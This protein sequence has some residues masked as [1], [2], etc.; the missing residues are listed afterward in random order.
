M[1]LNR[2]QN[3]LQT[4]FTDDRR[5]PHN[6]RRL[7]FWYDA[8]G[9][10]QE[11]FD[12]LN[13]EGIE[14]IQLAD[15]PFYTKYRLLIEDPEQ[16][17]LLYAPFAEPAPID[18]WLLDLQL[19]GL[20]FAADQ[21]ALLY[22]DLGFHD[23]HLETVIRQ[24]PNFFNSNKRTAAIV[25][26]QLAP[27]TT[28]KTL[29]L[30]LL[31]AIAGLKVP[32]TSALIRHIFM[33]G[34]LESDNELWQEITRLLSAETFWQIAQD[35]FHFQDDKPSLKKLLTRLLI[36]HL[37]LSLQGQLPESL[38]TYRLQSGQQAYAFIDQWLRDQRDLDAFKDFSRQIGDDLQIFQ[39]L[40][41]LSTETLQEAA[42][43]EAIDQVIIRQCVGDILAQSK[44]ISHWR[45]WLPSRRPLPWFDKYQAIYDALLAA[46]ALLE[47]YSQYKAGFPITASQLFSAYSQELYRFDQAYR[48]FIVAS[49]AA[50]GDVLKPV[51]EQIE[52]LYVNWYLA[53]LGEVWS[54]SLGQTWSIEGFFCQSKFFTTY[55]A[56]ILKRSDRE[57]VFVIIS[58]ALRY[59][60][61]AELKDQIEKELRGEI[62]LTSQLS[63]LPS[64][65]RLGMAALLP[66]TSL[67]LIP[68]SNEVKR[69]GLSTLGAEARQK[70]LEQ[71]SQVCSKVLSSAEILDSNTEQGRELIKPHRLFYIY[72]DVID[73]IGDK[74][75]SEREVFT[76][77][78]KANQQ[79][80]RL[81][82]RLCNSLNGTHVI[83]TA[84]HGFLYQRRS[85]EEPDKL[86][87]PKADDIIKTNRR[88][89]LRSQAIAEKGTVA[90]PVPSVDREITAVVPRGSMRFSVQGAG[91]QYVHGGASLQEVCV[92]VI[93]YRHKRAEKGDDGPI[94]KVGVQ[95][96][97]RTR[98][99]TN[100]RFRVSLIQSDAA[101]GRWRSRT[102]TLGLYD[103][104]NGQALTDIKTIDLSSS[105]PNPSEREFPQN[106]TVILVNPPSSASLII[107]D[108]DDDEELVRETWTVDLAIQNLFGDF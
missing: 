45:G 6:G 76:A 53:E 15:T 75:A 44:E 16:N 69:D 36:T 73:A 85:I 101:I 28:E 62:L 46:I 94:Q 95:I 22:A 29:L 21:A 74:A 34:L 54:D 48:Q 52:G 99:V 20:N 78:T 72:Q 25:A 79:I 104:V 56:P 7:V 4:L 83:I 42:T 77:C 100:N 61:A 92:P 80:L 23:R 12:E 57:K 40:E 1:S 67:N 102:V 106:L 90:F 50:I 17:F 32:D 88:Y 19:G 35:Y 13:L 9:Q 3:N 108:A 96:N 18:N 14:K 66:E 87:L 81:V 24:Y 38:K 37:G 2:I 107:R 47:L 58:D 10:F 64:V 33:K 68:E 39:P 27:D 82:K 5:W 70:V 55:V 8:D 84:D 71:N 31:C 41:T 43:F 91:S 30:A 103:S 59:E 89:V 49:D 11:S 60:V 98:K 26:M 93:T 105:S 51:I 97:A 86:S 65:T 63:L